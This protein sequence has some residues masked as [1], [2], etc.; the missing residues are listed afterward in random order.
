MSEDLERK[1]T[2]WFT[3]GF[4]W[5]GVAAALALLLVALLLGWLWDPLFWV[6]FAAMIA[7]L[8]AARWSNRTAPDLADGIIAPCD[9]IVV[10]VTRTDAPGE[11]RMSGAETTRIRISSSPASTNRLYAPIAGSLESLITEEGENS[12]PIA[13]RPDADGLAVSYLMFESRTQQVGVRIATGGLGPRQE[14][15]VETGDI[16]RLGRVF[17]KRRLGG[18][19]DIYVPASVGQLIWPGQTLIGGET[20][21]GRLRS[22]TDEED[23]DVSGEA[24]ELPLGAI[25]DD[26]FDEDDYPEPDEADTPDDPAVLLARLKEATK[27]KPED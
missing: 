13:M 6:G 4:D 26:T 8:L 11:L 14:I 9:G 17:G 23:F 18:W 19:C 16:L 22:D 12:A 20:V 10:S 2:P 3:G 21:L 15:E 5:E 1:T 24:G 27:N 7:A 25:E